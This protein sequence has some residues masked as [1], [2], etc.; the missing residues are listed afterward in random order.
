MKKFNGSK[1][2][3]SPC[4]HITFS[5]LVVACCLTTKSVTGQSIAD[6][7]QYQAIQEIRISVY[8][9]NTPL[10]KALMEIGRKTELPVNYNASLFKQDMFTS[11]QDDDVSIETVLQAIL[12]DSISFRYMNGSVILQK[13]KQDKID[14]IVSGRV[15]DAA[16][17]ESLPGVNI[18]VKGT[19]IGTSTGS[20][21]SYSLTVPSAQDTLIFSFIGYQ[22][23]EIAI[24]ER[25]EINVV[26]QSKAITGREVVVV[27]YGEQ[28]KANL[29][30][31]VSEIEGQ[32][33][34]AR[35]NTKL[36][37]SLQGKLP[38]LNISHQNGNPADAPRINIRGF[39]SINGGSPLVLIDGVEGNIN[40]INPNNVESITVLKDAAASAIYGG[41]AAFG[42]VLVNTKE[43]SAD[44]P[45]VSYSNNF[46]LL[47]PTNRTDYLTDPYQSALL[48]DESFRT[49]TGNSYTGY[50]EQDYEELKRRSEDPSLPDVVVQNRNGR[51]Q[52]VYYGNTD[53]WNTLFQ[54]KRPTQTHNLSI[55]GGSDR[56]RGTLSGRFFEQD[57]ILKVQDDGYK[58]YNAR[59]KLDFKIN[60]WFSLSEKMRFSQSENTMFGEDDDGLSDGWTG[61]FNGNMWSH[62]MPF[63]V[64]YNPDGTLTYKTGFNNYATSG[65]GLASSIMYGKAMREVTNQELVNTI[66]AHFTPLKNLEFTANYTNRWSF[67]QLTQRTTRVP[68]SLHPGETNYFGDDELQEVRSRD[69]YQALN[70]YGTLNH[71]IGRHEFTETIGL[72][73]EH[74]KYGSIQANKKNSIS[75]NLNAL[76]LGSSDPRA[77]GSA[78]E[79]ALLGYFFRFNYNF[80][81][82]YLLEMNGRY[83]GTSRF[84]ED[85]RWGFFPSVSAGWVIS[86]ESFFEGLKD[87]ISQLKLRASYGSLGNQQV[88]TYAYTPTLS[89]GTA[90]YLVDGSKLEYV[91]PPGVN[92]RSISWEEVNTINLGLDASFLQ[93]KITAKGDVYERRTMGMLTQGKTLPAVLGT[94]S[95]KENAADLRT[96][97]FEIE[98]GYQN[99]FQLADKPFNFSLSAALSNQKTVITR[100]DNPNNFLGDFYEGQT[101]GEIWGYKID[102]FFKTD[103]EAASHTDQ[104]QVNTRI[105]RSPGK[106]GNPL[107]GDLKYMDLNGDGMIDNGDN[108]LENPGDRRII[109]NAIPQFPYSITLQTNWNNMDLSVFF[110][111]VAKQDWY[112]DEN[113]RAFWSYY[114]RGYSSFNRKDLIDKIWSPE[115]PDTYFP[116]LRSYVANRNGAELSNVN[117]RYLQSVAYLRLKN[118]TIGYT[119]PQQW[120]D[121]INARRIRIY[122][123]GE[124][125]LTF[126]SLTDY[127]DPEA[128]SNAFNF[129]NPVA[130]YSSRGAR[131]QGQIYP[132]SKI[133]SV[134]I[135]IDL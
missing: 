29:T 65:S 86:N 35:P 38:G 106:F 45:Q 28:K 2:K 43:T 74:A 105:E 3:F 92:P 1:R 66:E 98:L 58:S 61:P 13:K 115:N 123:S 80:D 116:R 75:V 126:S 56:L 97:G 37:Q 60:E 112:P 48:A 17:K 15:T 83:D 95:P 9:D 132:F 94:G 129:G 89:K 72:N 128:A 22:T 20:N 117:D 73:Q 5:I 77:L 96:R 39:T 19:N 30:Q 111:G 88:A 99:T 36:S 31:A 59:A 23:K 40:N 54:N 53:W 84:P 79:W 109:G 118:L 4:Q 55:S 103:E 127:I 62:A 51:E 114:A 16:Q 120:L 12:P 110:Q 101:M 49:S 63:Y 44:E 100:F 57:G 81:G 6:L 21:G 7:R 33:L 25:S 70:L 68:W 47:T 107:A 76:D 71:S 102:G 26:L 90:D 14:F 42:V 131:S 108:T 10:D 122:F 24:Q 104:S 11:F 87:E 135:N 119:L 67:D 133:Y 113:S 121:K 69:T 50:S 18:A 32:E 64:P 93:D 46:S 27:G 52:Y 91:N 8:F 82:R 78:R 41:R 134:G 34:A 125:L 124:N 130:D 85:S